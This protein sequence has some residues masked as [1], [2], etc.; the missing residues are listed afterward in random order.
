M[1]LQYL[2]FMWSTNPSILKS[3][4]YRFDLRPLYHSGCKLNLVG[5][6]PLYTGGDTSG[7]SI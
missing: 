4:V 1:F 2:M 6:V 5:V 3:S 7:R